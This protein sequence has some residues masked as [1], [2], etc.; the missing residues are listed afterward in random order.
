MPRQIYIKPVCSSRTLA[1]DRT[2]EGVMLIR[3]LSVFALLLLGITFVTI[4]LTA[5]V[6]SENP[7][8]ADGP[9]VRLDTNTNN[10][11]TGTNSIND[12]VVFT[13]TGNLNQERKYHV[14]IRLPDGRVLVAGGYDGNEFLDSAEIYD[15][16]VGSFSI[17]GSM[18]TGRHRLTATYLPDDK[19]LIVGGSTSVEL[20]DPVTEVFTETGNMNG[21]HSVHTAT[22]L[23]SGKV[24]IV[25]G[26]A[27]AEL[28]D[29]INETFSIVDTTSITRS[30]HSATLLSNGSVLI[31]GGVYL[32]PLDSAELFSPSTNSFTPTGSL[33]VAR[34][35]QSATLLD[36]GTV[37]LT[38]GYHP[39]VGGT[40]QDYLDSAEVY[41]PSTGL[42][43]LTDNMSLPRYK[44]TATRLPNGKILIAGGTGG[45]EYDSEDLY[46]QGES[47]FLATDKMLN[48]RYGHTDTLLEDGSILLAGGYF[49]GF[50]L[51]A[52]IGL[53]LPSN[54]FT[55]TLVAPSGWINTITASVGIMGI[56]SASPVIGGSLSNNA[57]DW[58]PWISIIGGEL[59]T[60]TWS[61]QSEGAAKPI[62]TR[63]LDENGQAAVVVTGTA[64]IDV[65]VPSSS[66]NSL[67]P[68]STSTILLI[69]SGSDTISGISTYDVQVRKGP[70]GDWMH[71]L[72][73]TSVT[74]T[75]Y[76]GA[77]GH[78]YYF[79]VRAL[80]NAGNVE[81]WPIDYDTSTYVE[82]RIMLP[83]IRTYPPASLTGIIR[84]VDIHYDGTGLGDPD[85]YV[86][87]MN[88]DSQRIQ[89]LDWSLRDDS[90]QQFFFPS[91]VIPPGQICRIFTDEFHPEWCGFS[92]G[93]GS[94]I[95]DDDGDCAFLRDSTG[96]PIDHYCY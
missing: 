73:S 92:F 11:F 12:N 33:N 40:G 14:A 66:M 78:T 93:S 36:N 38:G 19:I 28:Y 34:S 95:W 45:S 55:G 58:G 48:G 24:L 87:I 10:V 53:Y 74:N 41:D 15:P 25:G 23:P 89:L 26:S 27:P 21:Y 49:G 51:S 56:S 13:H 3:G 80:D 16:V 30:A 32:G 52:E 47:T 77:V 85:E 84:I 88:N 42:F 6:H 82:T 94:E 65:S 60:T 67:P 96:A 31:A 2:K 90:G 54:I 71:I 5:D 17:I 69:W 8:E 72:S 59:V 64:D 61:F 79:R 22:A 1:R 50:L 75:V 81:V 18:L 44:H 37:L 9:D 46:D 7:L 70:S 20:Y 76:E 68:T 57:S 91:H 63:L 35:W 39:D 83:Y 29:P 86:E 43:E 62:F 4:F